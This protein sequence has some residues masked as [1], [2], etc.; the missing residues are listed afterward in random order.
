M[1]VAVIVSDAEHSVAVRNVLPI[2][3][4]KTNLPS[5]EEIVPYPCQRLEYGRS[6]P[7]LWRIGLKT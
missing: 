5:M 6:I 3:S 4:L 7:A 2:I 1:V